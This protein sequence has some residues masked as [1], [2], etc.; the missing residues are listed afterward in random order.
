MEMKQIAVI[1]LKNLKEFDE[2]IEDYI[3]QEFCQKLKGEAIDTNTDTKYIF[4]MCE[5]DIGDRHFDNILECD[6]TR[7]LLRLRMKR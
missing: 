2:F 5:D 6:Q 4:I 1:G 7:L 3:P